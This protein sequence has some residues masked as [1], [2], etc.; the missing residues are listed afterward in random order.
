VANGFES[1]VVMS[2]L[3]SEFLG[4]RALGLEMHA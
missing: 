1:L 3:Q 2:V 4:R